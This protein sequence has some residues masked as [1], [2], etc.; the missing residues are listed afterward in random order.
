VVLSPTQN[1]RYSYNPT[2]NCEATVSA[3]PIVKSKRGIA[4]QDIFDD[5]AL[6]DLIKTKKNGI[7]FIWSPHMA[8]SLKAV[9]ELNAAAAELGQPVTYVMDPMADQEAAKAGAKAQKL[10][11]SSMRRVDSMELAMRNALVHF[12]TLIVYRDGKIC[13]TFQRGYRTAEKYRAIITKI[14]G[15]CE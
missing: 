7:I 5:A 3:T 15:K 10:D 1:I 9:P 8:L 6:D 14:F 13:D 12:P 2:K 4:T 11:D